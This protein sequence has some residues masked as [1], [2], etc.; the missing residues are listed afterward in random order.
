MTVCE[1]TDFMYP[2][3][4][5][6]YYPI[7]TQGEY[8]QPKK[9]WVFDKTIACNA[10]SVGGAGQ[11]NIKPETF[12]QYENK[13]IA[14]TKSDPRITSQKDTNAITNILITNIRHANDEV[15][16][17]E[18]AGVRSGRATI[19]EVATVEPY[20]SPFNTVEYY[21]MLWRRAENQTVGD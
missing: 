4:A 19:F 8:G 5:D 21:K 7:I 16:Y 9:D 15:I 13:L 12:L 1:S 20:V 2:M 17:K 18:T 10:T 14:R 3:K 6:V 11:E